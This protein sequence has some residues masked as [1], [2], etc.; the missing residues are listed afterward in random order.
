MA[1]ASE[2]GPTSLESALGATPQE[3]ES[4]ILRRAD[5]QEHPWAAAAKRARHNAVFS[6][7]TRECL[8]VNRNPYSVIGVVPGSESNH[9]LQ[10]AL[11]CGKA[12]VSLPLWSTIWPLA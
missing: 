2:R 9:S 5:L 1:D 11:I 8:H 12:Q 4:P 6:A 3:F 7:A 10:P